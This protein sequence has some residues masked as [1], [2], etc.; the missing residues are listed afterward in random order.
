MTTWVDLEA[1]DFERRLH[2]GDP[3]LDWGGD[4]NMK[5]VKNPVDSSFAILR[6]DE[7]GE[8]RPVLSSDPGAKLG[9][10]VLKKLASRYQHRDRDPYDPARAVIEHNRKVYARKA[11]DAKASSAEALEETLSIAGRSR[12]Q[13]ETFYGPKHPRAA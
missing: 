10:A 2:E 3:T 12:I 5:L 6:N 1:V 4:P 13:P 11:A 9:P 7:D 8:W